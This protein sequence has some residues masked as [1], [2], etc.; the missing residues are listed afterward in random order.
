[1]LNGTAAILDKQ[2]KC[3][4]TG[5][6]SMTMGIYGARGISQ[7]TTVTD[8]KPQTLVPGPQA[9]HAE[10]QAF[11]NEILPPDRRHFMLSLLNKKELARFVAYFRIKDIDPKNAD[12]VARFIHGYE[13]YCG[14]EKRPDRDSAIASLREHIAKEP[15]A[16]ALEATLNEHTEVLGQFVENY[17]LWD[18][19]D[20]P[21]RDGFTPLMRAI[22]ENDEI[23]VRDLILNGAKI[24]DRAL[25]LLK[26]ATSLLALV[27]EAGDPECLERVL[28]SCCSLSTPADLLN[29]L[30]IS[31]ERGDWGMLARMLTYLQDVHPKTPIPVPTAALEAAVRCPMTSPQD[32][33]QRVL[34]QMFRHATLNRQATHNERRDVFQLLIEL[35]QNDRSSAL[36]LLEP[37]IGSGLTIRHRM[38]FNLPGLIGLLVEAGANIRERDNRDHDLLEIAIGSNLSL[39]TIEEVLE[40]FRKAGVAWNRGVCLDHA[41]II[42]SRPLAKLLIE[43]GA[44][45]DHAFET[46]LLSDL[47][48]ELPL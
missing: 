1:V 22:E 25:M 39:S 46:W 8:E 41:M 32:Q 2:D 24:D 4:I 20:R 17:G 7:S 48:P 44:V 6:I 47:K 19:F 3:L 34:S 26:D 40:A 5:V 10:R 36:N 35:A 12:E 37:M 31:A 15:N 14:K 11:I 16:P 21:D 42:N 23:L 27:A 18:F 45:P 29:V 43:Y 33:R 13:Q 30:E 38:Q 9:T 28:T